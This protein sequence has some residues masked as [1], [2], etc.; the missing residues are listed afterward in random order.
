MRPTSG[1]PRFSAPVN[2]YA[3][4]KSAVTGASP[5]TAGGGLFRD[6]KI[7]VMA[8]G[9]TLPGRCIRCNAPT[10]LRLDKKIYWHNPWIYLLIFQLLIYAIVA[11]IV[12]KKAEVS[13]PVCQDHLDRRRNAIIVAWLI[14]LAGIILMPIGFS[15]DSRIA[16]GCAGMLVVLGAIVFGMRKAQL[17]APKKITDQWILLSGVSPEFLA[18]LP[19]APPIE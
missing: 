6:G 2:P 18:P 13:F 19:L 11:L 12:R 1:D 15:N 4:P 16:I 3:P 8:R 17:A 14:A 7:L 9:A 10:G 5:A